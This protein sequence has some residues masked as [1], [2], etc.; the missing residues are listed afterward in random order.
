VFSSSAVSSRIE[1]KLKELSD[2][3]E[4]E[5]CER[6]AANEQVWDHLRQIDDA[7][8]GSSETGTIDHVESED[9]QTW[10]TMQVWTTCLIS[11]EYKP[12]ILTGPHICAKS[13]PVALSARSSPGTASKDS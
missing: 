7:G 10:T 13:D 8:G 5:R 11:M 2:A 6:I 12:D 1:D 4:K 9:L 3:L